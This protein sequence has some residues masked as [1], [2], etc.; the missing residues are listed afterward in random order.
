MR[1]EAKSQSGEGRRYSEEVLQRANETAEI[2]EAR[3]RRAAA[4]MRHYAEEYGQQAESYARA[5]P[6]MVGAVAFG[7]GAA[8]GGLMPR[9]AR[10]AQSGGGHGHSH[11]DW[12]DEEDY[13]GA[14]FAEGDLQGEGDY[15][16]AH[17][18]RES[19]ED[20]AEHGDPGRRAREAAADLSR[21]PETY[22]KAEAAGRKPAQGSQT[23]GSGTAKPAGNG[24]A[25]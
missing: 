4:S 9:V 15:R 16:A 6:F 3:A 7:L 14:A 1:A 10:M 11:F 13:G 20:F 2:A 25:R 19:T 18:Y 24:G 21:D 8:I 12:E 23:A 5:H 22:R 17:H